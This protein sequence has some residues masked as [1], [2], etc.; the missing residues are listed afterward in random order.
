MTSAGVFVIII[1]IIIVLFCFVVCLHHGPF[2]VLFLVDLA[3]KELATFIVF[4]ISVVC[5]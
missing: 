5:R 1:I 3:N 2:F 4:L